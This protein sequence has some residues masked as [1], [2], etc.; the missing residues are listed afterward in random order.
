M[1]H[2]YIL[3]SETTQRYYVGSTQDVDNRLGEHNHSESASTRGG[4]PWRV[5]R[6]EDFDT[7]SEAMRRERQTRSRGIERYLKDLTKGEPG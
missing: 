5:V 7:R 4:V 2:V 6:V 1:I 3:H